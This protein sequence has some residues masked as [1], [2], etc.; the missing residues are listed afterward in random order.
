MVL[1]TLGI[2]LAYNVLTV[3]LALAGKMSPLLCANVMPLSSLSTI[4]AVAL[5]LSPRAH[6]PT[7]E[8]AQV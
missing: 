1:G 7:P 5:Q 6:G 4:F 3:S 8:E 2:A